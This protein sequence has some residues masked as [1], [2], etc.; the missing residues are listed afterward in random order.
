MV[1]TLCLRG[2]EYL[3]FLVELKAT[4]HETSKRCRAWATRK[5][6]TP[7]VKTGRRELPTCHS[8]RHIADAPR[9]PM[10]ALSGLRGR[11][12]QSHA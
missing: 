1:E 9:E 10:D 7:R 11:G 8:I 6:K 3:G 2:F 12:G 5:G 4:D